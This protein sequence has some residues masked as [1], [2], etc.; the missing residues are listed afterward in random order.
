[1]LARHSGHPEPNRT[2]PCHLDV[3][4]QFGSLVRAAETRAP[5]ASCVGPRSLRA[6]PLPQPLS[7]SLSLAYSLFYTLSLTLSLT[8]SLSYLLSPSLS[9]SLPCSI[10]LPH[11]HPPSHLLPSVLHSTLP[12]SLP[13]SNISFRH[14]RS[15]IR[16]SQQPFSESVEARKDSPSASPPSPLISR[17]PPY[18]GRAPA[19]TAGRRGE[20]WS[21][22]AHTADGEAPTIAPTTTTTTTTTTST[23]LLIH[24]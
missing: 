23:A 20:A 16:A 12:P 2:A 3:A 7:L 13:P 8:Y 14:P 17:G 21:A 24:A 15:L 10:A 6:W 5:T 19:R 22:Y 11:S 18:S 9:L 1:M 4:R